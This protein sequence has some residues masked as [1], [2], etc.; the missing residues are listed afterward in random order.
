MFKETNNSSSSRSII[1]PTPRG[2][3]NVW[4]SVCSHNASRRLKIMRSFSLSHPMVFSFKLKF[5]LSFRVVLVTFMRADVDSG[6]VWATIIHIVLVKEFACTKQSLLIR[7]FGLFAALFPFCHL[8]WMA[9]IRFHCIEI[10]YCYPKLRKGVCAI[11]KLN[12]RGSRWVLFLRFSYPSTD[13]GIVSVIVHRCG[14]TKGHF[15]SNGIECN[16]IICKTMPHIKYQPIHIKRV[17]IRIKTRR[18]K[19]LT[20]SRQFKLK[21]E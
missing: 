11:T 4:N 17:N 5:S 7:L 19:W 1:K 18:K 14:K 2:D 20:S 3:L 10:K 12:N 6:K 16:N 13:A 15:Y 8:H 9:G 21:N